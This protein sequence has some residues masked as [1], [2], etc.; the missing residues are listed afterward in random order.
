MNSFLQ[1]VCRG[2]NNSPFARH[3]EAK[4]SQGYALTLKRLVAML[5]R[6]HCESLEDDDFVEDKHPWMNANRLSL[7]LEELRTYS[8]HPEDYSADDI[9]C[10]LGEVMSALWTTSWSSTEHIPI[11]DPTIL[12]CAFLSLR[13]DGSYMPA[14]WITKIFAQLKYLMRLHV[15]SCVAFAKDPLQQFKALQPWCTDCGELS[16][17]SALCNWQ[18]IA[19]TIVMSEPSIPNLFWVDRKHWTK[20]TYAGHL[21]TLEATRSMHEAIEKDLITCWEEKVLL[22]TQLRVDTST[23][24]ENLGNRTPGYSFLTEPSNNLQ[25]YRTLLFDSIQQSPSLHDRF[26]ITKPSQRHWNQAALAQWLVDYAALSLLLLVRCEML[27]GGPARGTELTSMLYCSSP[28]QPVRNLSLLDTYVMLLTTYSKTTSL[29]GL[30]RFIP[31]ALD[32]VTADILVQSLIIARPFAILAMQ[33]CYPHT[34]EH[35]NLYR[36][37]LFVNNDRRFTTDDLSREMGRYSLQFLGHAHGI[38]THRHMTVAWRRKLCPSA[39]DILENEHE[40]YV[41]AEQAGHSWA[42]EKKIYGVSMDALA[43]SSEDFLAVFLKAST[44]WQ[45]AMKTVP[46]RFYI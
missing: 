29:S 45:K 41:G 38:Q 27:S 13:H 2:L 15:I 22:G 46:G 20:L 42:V 10:A 40:D 4:S 21:I 23:L 3:Q 5:F 35:S 24:K 32:S 7:S 31:H 36:S 14:K 19:T 28:E 11:A 33:T 16:T 17:F 37:Y 39:T 43:G 1:T 30:D 25:Q 18:H 8:S 34:P 44:N 6:L 9:R 12:F 26:I